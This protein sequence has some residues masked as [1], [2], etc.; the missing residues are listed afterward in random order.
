LDAGRINEKTMEKQVW[1]LFHAEPAV[2]EESFESLCLMDS[3]TEVE[4][5]HARLIEFGHIRAAWWLVRYL[6]AVQTS[7]ALD[8]LSALTESSVEIIR[9][10]ASLGITKLPR[11]MQ[12]DLLIRML[13]LSWTHEVRFAARQLAEAGSPKAVPFLLE[14]LERNT[15]LLVQVEI[16]KT[17]GR[18]K[19]ERAF[20]AVQKFARQASGLVQEEA[21]ACL[22]RFTY[23]LRLSLVRQCLDSDN[24]KVRRITLLAL[25]RYR[26]TRWEK[27]IARGIAAEKDLRVLAS[28]L[29]SIRTMETRPF[30]LVMVR[31]AVSHGNPQAAMMAQ[32]VL[33]KIRSRRLFGWLEK[34]AKTIRPEDLPALLRLLAAYSGEPR[35]FDIL[36]VFYERKET[37]S[38]YFQTRWIA[39]ECMAGL[40]DARV[41]GYLRDLIREGGPFSHAAALALLGQIREGH[42]PEVET[43]LSMDSGRHPLV[44]RDLL[45]FL[46]RLPDDTV[47]P[48]PVNARIVEFLDSPD[49][50]IRYLAI[51]CYARSN[52]GEALRRILGIAAATPDRGI[53]T[54]CM[55][56]V[57][58]ILR[59]HPALLEE[60]LTVSFTVRG[61]YP[62][63]SGLFNNVTLEAPALDHI[64]GVLV[65]KAA[66]VEKKFLS[67]KGGLQAARLM[68]LLKRLA[69]RHPGAVIRYFEKFNGPDEEAAILLRM[70]MFARLHSLRGLDARFMAQRM[71]EA[72]PLARREFL[73]FFRALEE[74]PEEIE[75]AVF[76]AAP[77]PDSGFFSEWEQTVR[78]WLTAAGR[79][80]H[81]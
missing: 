4:A 51:R 35:T 73:R 57:H 74:V 50:M 54:G 39:L 29:P 61:V 10:E 65:S 31:L 79:P 7:A 64:L 3:E 19:D 68:L 40:R 28:V 72:G 5:V 53:R 49:R 38:A 33:K 41:F 75:K 9:E 2:Q 26:G 69:L 17:L 22:A 62:L 14:A 42:W 77:D 12:I 27:F 32:T 1:D 18:L 23:K 34:A 11:E 55:K 63:V 21:L 45:S 80:S 15:H 36:R 71:L 20:G 52:F 67:E 81:E 59:R 47:F 78:L 46:A 30:F 8:R 24:P 56:A 76:A 6:V 16:L 48:D 44:I 58:H 37:D 13:K 60:A 66:A 25:L 70:M 43:L